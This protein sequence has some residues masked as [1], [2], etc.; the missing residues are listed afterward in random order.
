M[1]QILKIQDKCFN[2]LLKLAVQ[3]QREHRQG[4]KEKQIILI[5]RCTAGGQYCNFSLFILSNTKYTLP[6]ILG[7]NSATCIG[8]CRYSIW[9]WKLWSNHYCLLM[10]VENYC[11]YHRKFLNRNSNHILYSVS[12]YIHFL[13]TELAKPIQVY[14]YFY[15]AFPKKVVGCTIL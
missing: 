5:L 15:V 3:P 11:P 14:L 6:C 7:I 4:E 8:I 2:C 10:Y 9:F 1:L 13:Q 12:T